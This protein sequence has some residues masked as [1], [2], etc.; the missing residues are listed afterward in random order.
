MRE[1]RQC[2]GCGKP[3]TEIFC[4]ASADH[5][6]QWRYH[7]TK[8]EGKQLRFCSGCEEDLIRMVEP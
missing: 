4:A 6:D 5:K 3:Y 1:F 2:D 7:D 8:G